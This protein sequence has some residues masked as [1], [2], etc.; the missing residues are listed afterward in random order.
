MLK[1]G[2]AQ[3]EI[4]PELPFPR[5][6][7]PYTDR[8]IDAYSDPT[9]VS[10]LALES[11][12]EA[13]RA[14]E[15]VIFVSCDI[16]LIK[17]DVAEELR[18]RIQAETGVGKSRAYIAAT[19]NHQSPRF[20]SVLPAP[21]ETPD[22]QIRRKV[23][24]RIVDAARQA[25]SNL[26]PAKLGYRRGAV[27]NCAFNRRYIMSNGRVKT[28]PGTNPGRLMVEGPADNDVHALWFEDERG[29]LIAVAVH[30]TAHPQTMSATSLASADY[31]GAV[32][33]TIQRI[34]GADIPVLFLQGAAGNQFTIDLNQPGYGRGNEWRL[35]LG[36]MI[37]AEAV[38]LI[39]SR[40]AWDHDPRFAVKSA[41][42]PVPYR[43]FA[44][45]QV[46]EAEQK[47]AAWSKSD[48]YDPKLGWETYHTYSLIELGRR[49]QAQPY[50]AA[51]VSA[52]ILGG[53]TLL[54]FPGEMFVEYQLELKARLADLHRSLA[55]V[56][57]YTNGFVGY[58]PTPQAFALGGY[59]TELALASKLAPEAGRLLTDR[60]LQLAEELFGRNN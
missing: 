12:S 9:M 2:S 35:R 58:M 52:I 45:E 1:V 46:R 48:K 14:D 59:E 49:K 54:T 51:E 37:G 3:V 19:H 28:N 30:F 60:S 21:W 6:G 47:W 33:Q 7:G 16:C 53:V 20:A 8:V 50:V 44:D 15:A 4:T 24:D 25:W 29:E 11:V 40:S 42:V 18:G 38:R 41:I 32:R 39:A 31:P 57:G 27:D 5:G 34:F 26:R 22:P 23:C 13:G 43:E 17:E 36:R 55:V 56:V 10:A